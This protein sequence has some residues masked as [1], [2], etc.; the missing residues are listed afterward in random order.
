L[1]EDEVVERIEAS[2][3]E[4]SAVARRLSLLSLDRLAAVLR[5]CRADERNVIAVAGRFE[6]EVTQTCVVSLQPLGRRLSE[7]VSALYSLT[8]ADGGEAGPVEVDA[9]ED[10][11][12]PVGPEGLDLGEVVVQHLAVALD[13]YPRGDD[14]TLD[15]LQWAGRDGAEAAKAS[16][17]EGLKSLSRGR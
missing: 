16:P 5:V 15:S 11:P 2:E 7:D 13:P 8:A 9:A 14:A 6:A 3:A 12:E 1:G 10:S 17:F 4:R